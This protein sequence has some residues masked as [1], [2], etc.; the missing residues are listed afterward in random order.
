M[1][2]LVQFGAWQ[3]VDHG[4]NG[5]A[6]RW[7]RAHKQTG[8]VHDGLIHIVRGAPEFQKITS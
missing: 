3:S 6:A 7:S 2:G 4:A 8:D 1:S 5:V